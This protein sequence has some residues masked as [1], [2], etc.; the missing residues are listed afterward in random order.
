MTKAN[1]TLQAPGPASFKL[2]GQRHCVDA[3]FESVDEWAIVW[4]PHVIPAKQAVI[5]P[6]RTLQII[7]GRTRS[8]NAPPLCSRNATCFVPLAPS[9]HAHAPAF[10]RA[11][12]SY[13][14]GREQ[15][16][17]VSAKVSNMSEADV[18]PLRCLVATIALGRGSVKDDV[19]QVIVEG[20]R[21][22]EF[23]VVRSV[24]V[25][26]E[27]AFIQQL[28]SNIANGNEA[29]AIIL[30]G[31]VGVGPRDA[32]CEAVNELVDRKMEGFGEAYRHLLFESGESPASVAIARATAGVCNRLFVVAL[33]RQ[34]AAVLRLAMLKLVVPMLPDAVRVALGHGPPWAS[35]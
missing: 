12:T 3:C 24:T 13:R 22:A 7:A 14:I 31:G 9:P 10:A 17:E 25:N 26:R 21:A 5:Q 35:H 28:V 32:T 30:I 29:D 8:I 27:K 19:T 23:V 33:P 16:T 6:R 18:H 2:A 11:E 1:A 34:T 4:P 20:L 15:S